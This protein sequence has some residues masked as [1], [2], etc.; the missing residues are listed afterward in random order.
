LIVEL[1]EKEHR[2]S[3]SAIILSNIPTQDEMAFRIGTVREVLCRGLHKLEQENL[4][5][6][7]RGKIIIYNLKKLKELAPLEEGTIFPI[8]LP[9][10]DLP[11]ELSMGPG[12]YRLPQGQSRRYS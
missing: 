9:M 12:S 7:K 8:T 10:I 6:V 4:I 5:K 2:S 11:V 1:A 3:D